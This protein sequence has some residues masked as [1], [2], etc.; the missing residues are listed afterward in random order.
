ME[1]RNIYDAFLECERL[2]E[3]VDKYAKELKQVIKDKE[4][5]KQLA[6]SKGVDNAK[7][8]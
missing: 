6:L 1:A 3:L 4:A 7:N 2:R 8:N 5:W